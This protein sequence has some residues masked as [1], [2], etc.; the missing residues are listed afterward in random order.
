VSEHDQDDS[1]KIPEDLIPPT[2]GEEYEFPDVRRR[3]YGSVMILLAS[4]VVLLASLFIDDSYVN[5]GSI[6]AAVGGLALGAYTLACSW[7]LRVSEKEAIL[8]A[9]ASLSF[10][11]GPA[12]IS[13]GWR[14]PLSRPVWRV[15]AYSSE[16]PRPKRR[17][18]VAIDAV[19][20]EVIDKIDENNPEEE[21][22]E[23][24]P[25]GD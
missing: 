17:G 6:V 5:T 12:S 3:A 22:D 15:L 1:E 23:S 7:H 18:Y 24:Q 14:G 4:G 16:A 13:I 9:A 19:S 10:P 25:T 11:I 2:T 21:W 20:G 8:R